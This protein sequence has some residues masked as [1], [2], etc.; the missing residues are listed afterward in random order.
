MRY[1]LIENELDF[2][3]ISLVT[4]VLGLIRV[5]IAS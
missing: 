1:Q 5:L 2:I 3:I 4:I